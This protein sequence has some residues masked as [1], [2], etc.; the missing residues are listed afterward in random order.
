MAGPC[1]PF[2]RRML[3]ER[4][5]GPSMRDAHTDWSPEPTALPVLDGCPRRA[6]ALFSTPLGKQGQTCS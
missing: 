4:S 2:P 3:R 1:S 5:R 6:R